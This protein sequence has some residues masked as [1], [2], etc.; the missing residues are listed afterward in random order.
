[1]SYPL[2]IGVFYAIKKT[3]PTQMNRLRDSLFGDVILCGGCVR[4]GFG[5]ICVNVQILAGADLGVVDDD[6]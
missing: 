5:I 3:E 6:P 1:M 4:I 2:I